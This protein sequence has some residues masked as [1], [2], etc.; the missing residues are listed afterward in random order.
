MKR[1]LAAL[2]A[3]L[4]SLAFA[5]PFVPIG[6]TTNLS[7]TGT[8]ANIT[9]PTAGTAPTQVAS[10][11]DF[12]LYTYVFSN[13]GTQ[14]IFFRCD[15]TTATASNAMPIQAGKDY[16]IA[17]DKSVTACSFIA[18]GAGSSVYATIGKGQ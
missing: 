1:I 16:E 8:A 9:L 5:F 11:A 15:G 6:P 18:A 17:L 12:G 2:A 3:C 7:V 13:I 10:T 4:A 14:T